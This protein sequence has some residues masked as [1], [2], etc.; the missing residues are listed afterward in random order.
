M[1]Y[2]FTDGNISP[3]YG[4]LKVV[5]GISHIGIVVQDIDEVLSFL[6]DSFG[7]EEIKRIEIPKIKQI[8]SIV[9]IGDGYFELIEPTDAEGVAGKFLRTKG[10]GLHHICLLCDDAVELC[11]SLEKRGAK[12]I[13]KTPEGRYRGGFIHP[14]TSKGILFEL[15]ER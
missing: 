12:I 1:R 4:D 10:G 9:K 13:G 2:S 6:R 8:S 11:E 3:I 7:A 15:K 5:K 14:K